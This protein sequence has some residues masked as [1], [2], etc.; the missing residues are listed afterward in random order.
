MQ[1]LYLE[2]SFDQQAVKK[3]TVITQKL[4]VASFYNKRDR[5]HS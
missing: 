3:E 5:N 1:K 2:C 4:C